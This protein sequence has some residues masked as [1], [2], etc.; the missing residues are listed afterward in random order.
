MRPP[1]SAHDCEPIRHR[2]GAVARQALARAVRSGAPLS[3]AI[4][5]SEAAEAPRLVLHRREGASGL[6]GEIPAD[7]PLRHDR[8]G[9]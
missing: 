5:R 6:C 3:A 9:E 7:A 2:P 4:V 1:G 8:I